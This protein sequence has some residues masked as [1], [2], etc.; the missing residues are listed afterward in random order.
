MKK[1]LLGALIVSSSFAGNLPDALYKC[2]MKN[3]TP[4]DEKTIAEYALSS[5]VYPSKDFSSFARI[6]PDKVKKVTEETGEI[7]GRVFSTSCKK[8]LKEI[9]EKESIEKA[10]YDLYEAVR[11]I[12]NAVMMREKSLF[13]ASKVNKMQKWIEEGFKK[14][15]FGKTVHEIYEETKGNDE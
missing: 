10:H 13:D 3:L 11:K 12:M 14:G 2:V 8:E 5:I 7:I 15:G 6:T 4:N 9:Y 1:I